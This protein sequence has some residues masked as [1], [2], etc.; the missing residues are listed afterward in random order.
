MF[1]IMLQ[2]FT[3]L[4]VLSID[5]TRIWN[6]PYKG[7]V[8]LTGGDYSNQ[9]LVEVYC[10]GQWGTVCDDNFST[11]TAQVVCRQLGYTGYSTWRSGL[12]L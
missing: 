12:T 4:F 7:M 8:R 9:G 11:T 6:S 1:H 2:S 5:S 3:Y 10:N